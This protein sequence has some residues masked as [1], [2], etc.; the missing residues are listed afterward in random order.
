MKAINILKTFSWALLT[1]ILLTACEDDG[2]KIYLSSINGGDF[3]VTKTDVQLSA[4]NSKEVVLSLAWT[5]DALAVSDPSMSAPNVLSTY[6]QISTES[7][8]SSNVIESLESTFSKAYTGAELNTI[9][10][11]LGIEADKKTPV[12]FRLKSKTGNN[13]DP[14]YSDVATV[15]ITSYSIDMSLGFILDKD[16]LDMGYTLSSTESDGIYA[17][18]MG[19]AGWSNFYLLEG[20]GTIWGNDALGDSPFLLSSEE[21]ANKRWNFWFP[22]LSGCYFTEVN[23]VKKQWSALFIPSLKVSGDLQAEMTFDRPKVKWTTV[24][25][26]TSAS[27]LKL[28]FQAT[29]KQY[30]YS[31]GTDD[32]KAIDTPV[33]FSQNGGNIILTSQAGEISVTVPQAGD[34]TL[35]IDLR[36]PNAWTCKVVSGSDE[37]EEV[38]PYVYLPGIDDAISGAW[39]FDRTLSL[40]DEDKLSYAG[41]V[42]VNSKFGYSI[43]VEKDNWDDKYTLAEGSAVGG[44]LV[45][46]GTD[47]LPAPSAGLYLIDTSI[48]D[49]T[50]NLTAIGNQI[51]VVG[52]DDKWEFDVPLTETSNTGIYSGKITFKGASPWGFT[53]HVKSGDWDRKFGGS[54]GKLNYRGS[55]ITDDASLAPGTY[56]M[57][58]DLIKGTYSITQ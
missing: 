35:E 28:K 40:Y 13:M 30:N 38:N 12:Y 52:L 10:K 8:F 45:F 54:K 11:N 6:I 21:D 47:N 14:A 17:G 56:Q 26:A 50:Y 29:G 42:N 23:T 19:A 58:V 34:Y 1:L 3:V 41:V 37:P 16:K 2:D 33:A 4:E 7:D 22:G 49:L 36:N 32:A 27:T 24:F 51:F 48:K 31:T 55:N 57:T 53:I 43:H 46:K 25:K 9:A 5:K 20:D 18:F 39:T 15:N 44:T